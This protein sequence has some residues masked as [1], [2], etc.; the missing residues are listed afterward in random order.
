MTRHQVQVIQAPAEEAPRGIK[1]V[2][3]AGTTANMGGAD[4]RQ[5][6]TSLLRDQPITI[7]N[8]ARE[9]WDSTWREDVDFI[10]Y[11]EQVTWELDKQDKADL[12]I[13]Y[14]HPASQAPVSLLELGLCAR[15]PGKAIVMCPDGYWKRGNVQMVC[16]RYNIDMEETL[17]GLARAVV[18]RACGVPGKMKFV[19]AASRGCHYKTFE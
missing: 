11:R 1:S 18:S 15:T 8:P 4:W 3:L 16:R 19:N 5:A 17:E 14:F 12:V 7:Y 9:D 10:P 13:V 6:L 2:F